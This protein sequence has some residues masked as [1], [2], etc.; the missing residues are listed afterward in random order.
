M[1][2]CS[3]NPI[4]NSITYCVVNGKNPMADCPVTDIQ[5]LD[6]NSTSPILKDDSYTKIL[7]PLNQNKN[8]NQ[9]ARFYIA[10]TKNGYKESNVP[11]QSLMWKYGQPCAFTDQSNVY[12]AFSAVPKFYRLEVE[13]YQ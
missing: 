4:A 6:V 13:R 10:F 7:S 8:L 11:L 5:I 1:V 12:S 3:K 2:A 9:E